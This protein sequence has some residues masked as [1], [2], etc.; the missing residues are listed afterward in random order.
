MHCYVMKDLEHVFSAFREA[1]NKL[2]QLSKEDAMT[3]YIAELSNI[4]V[5]WEEKVLLF[6]RFQHVKITISKCN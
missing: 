1:W 3:E 2:G 6:I 4:D 5:D